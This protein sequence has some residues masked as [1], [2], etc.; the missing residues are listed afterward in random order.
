MSKAAILIDGGYL[1]KRLPWVT[2]HGVVV[3]PSRAFTRVET[4][5]KTTSRTTNASHFTQ[6]PPVMARQALA[7]I[8]G[9]AGF[10]GK[11]AGEAE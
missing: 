6:R 10:L 8:V 2:V 9:S 3:P 4:E 1:L 7:N 11:R 5:H